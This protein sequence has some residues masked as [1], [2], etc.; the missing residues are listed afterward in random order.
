MHVCR[1]SR[2]L[3]FQVGQCPESVKIKR[4]GIEIKLMLMEGKEAKKED[5]ELQTI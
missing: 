5:K 4:G 3:H 1:V 2:E